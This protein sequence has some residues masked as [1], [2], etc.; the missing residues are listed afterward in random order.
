[1]PLVLVTGGTGALGPA[2]V[3]AFLAA[4]WNCRTLARTPPESEAP[5]SVPHTIADINDR[6]ALASVMKDVDVVV[7]LAA[8]LHASRPPEPTDTEYKR[9]NV[10]G[11]LAALET[12]H[13]QGV[14][15]F[16]F[17]STI[18]VYG[19]E[20]SGVLDE[21]APPAPDTPYSRS[22]Y[23][24]ETELHRWSEHGSRPDVVILRLSAVYGPGIKGNYDRLVRAIARRRFVPVGTGTNRRTLVYEDDAARA[25][26][27]AASHPRASGGTFNVVGGVHTVAEITAA[28]STALGCRPPLFHVPLP[29]ARLAVRG[30]ESFCAGI[31]YRSP[32]TVAI[33]D[34][35]TEEIVVRGDRIR[36]EL[37]LTP[38]IALVEGWR[39]TVAGMRAQGRLA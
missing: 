10:E 23:E 30:I 37:G 5:P 15:R 28:I 2:V 32:V 22:K 33:L 7:H 38:Q 31:G 35:Y 1:M 12:A 18:A 14:H 6:A 25:I 24:A 17:T 39:R 26:V 11:V 20:R 29:A 3:R 9:I 36:E 16:V 8:L 27:A 4:G 13:Q 19:S 34:K 21:A